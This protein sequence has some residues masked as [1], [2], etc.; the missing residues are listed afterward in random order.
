MKRKDYQELRE[1][2]AK[3]RLNKDKQERRKFKEKEKEKK[4]KK[5]KDKE[6]SPGTK[7]SLLA[8]LNPAYDR[9][10]PKYYMQ[11]INQEAR[12]LLEE[13]HTSKPLVRHL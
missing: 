7:G 8:Q 12:D 9:N 10:H 6:P 3:R 2:M 11:D 5:D 13:H 4:K 1:A